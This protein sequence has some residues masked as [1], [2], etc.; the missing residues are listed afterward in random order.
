MKFGLL[1]YK[2][3]NYGDDIQSVAAEEFLPKVD[4]HIDRDRLSRYARK[5][6]FALILNGWFLCPP[7]GGVH[8]Y[9]PYQRMFHRFRSGITG[10]FYDWPPPPN[11]RPLLIAH[12]IHT[13]EILTEEGLAF[14]KKHEPVGC[15]DLH[16]VRIL[17]ARGVKAYFSGC[18]TLTL[19][20]RSSE[21]D[22]K[23]YFVDPFSWSAGHRFRFPGHSDFKNDLWDKFPKK[24][25]E[26]AIFLTHDCYGRKDFYPFTRARELVEIYSRAKLVITSRLHVVLPCLALGTPVILLYDR[27]RTDVRFDGVEGFLKRISFQDIEAGNFGIDWEQPAPNPGNV[28]KLAADL[29]ARCE[30]FVRGDGI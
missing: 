1:Y 4:Y 21:R 10:K 12:Y 29:R 14:Y 9:K 22:G 7:Y 16:T 26:E 30:A 25:R 17:E 13:P 18:L 3:G 20:N 2:T 23:I 5:G 27:T 6:P 19:Q 28:S 24:V 8:M 11:I 15:R